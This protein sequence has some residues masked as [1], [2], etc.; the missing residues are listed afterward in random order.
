MLCRG[1][2]G[3]VSRTAFF[4]FIA[5]VVAGDRASKWAV[6]EAMGLADNISLVPGLASL[7]HV[8]NP[9]A[10]FGI[11]AG[12]DPLLRSVFFTI[13]TVAVVA[14]LTGVF[15]RGRLPGKT[16]AAAAAAIVGGALGNAW[17][18]VMLGEVVDFIDLYVGA[19]HWPAFNVADSFITLGAVALVISSL[20][21]RPGAA[22]D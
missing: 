19:W 11:L 7:V 1:G 20:R 14:V 22:A 4:S 8:R 16:E 2:R 9:G 15:M 6:M 17:D 5:A 13:V 18:R 21:E 12:A 3:F 10:A